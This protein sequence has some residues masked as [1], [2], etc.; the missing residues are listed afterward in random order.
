MIIMDSI[1]KTASQVE[2]IYLD[3]QTSKYVNTAE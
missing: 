1:K 3:M 2:E